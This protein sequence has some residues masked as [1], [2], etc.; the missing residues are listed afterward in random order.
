[1][2]VLLSTLF[3]FLGFL[4]LYAGSL[5]D[6]LPEHS[7]FMLQVENVQKARTEYQSSPLADVLN[8]MDP[9]KMMMSAY[10]KALE[11]G[12]IEEPGDLSV[13]EVEAQVT[14]YSLM[15]KGILDHVEGE[16]ILGV[17]SLEN[18]ITSFQEIETIRSALYED[19]DVENEMESADMEALAKQE[20][21]LETRELFAI[22]NEFYFLAEVKEGDALLAKL[23][24]M[25][26]EALQEQDDEY[27]EV[28]LEKMDWDGLAV[29][30]LKGRDLDPDAEAEDQDEFVNISWWTVK[31]NV[32]I[33]RG[34]EEGL[35][36]T[37]LALDAPPANRLSASPGYVD[38][39]QFLGDQETK[40][41]MDFSR[42]DPLVRLAL[43]PE[44]LNEVAQGVKSPAMVMDWLG[45]DALLPY[46]LGFSTRNDGMHGKARF[47]F[48]RETPL[49]RML[50]DP[51]MDPAPIP[52]FLHKD[53]GQISSMRWS[54]GAGLR[55][56]ETE[57][58]AFQP[59]LTAGLGVVKA[60]MIGQLGMDV[61][62]QFLDHFDT[63]LVMAQQLDA[64]VME[65]MLDMA[66]ESDPAKMMQFRME[67][68]TNGQNYLLGLQLKN[69]E[70]V[71]SGL[72]TLL[73]RVHP[74][75][76]PEP[77]MF[78][79]H[80]IHSPI[81]GGEDS[82]MANLI[83][84]TILDGYLVVAIGNET[85]LHD[86]IR[87]SNEPAS[88]L[89]QDPAFQAFRDQL[90]QG[91]MFEYTPRAVQQSAWS[92]IASSL[93]AAG[94]ELEGLPDMEKLGAV[95]GDSFSTAIRKGTVFETEIHSTFAPETE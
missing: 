50:I 84:Y 56:V 70:L 81:P 22:I 17:G 89:I 37:L 85:M 11:E 60:M 30:T 40:L 52:S 78:Q 63:G 66:E 65:K 75:G 76:I 20:D 67:H 21:D 45:A 4:P 8:D 79:G 43:G 39:M 28:A 68:P 14:K 36:K 2:N 32:W 7:V 12:E 23:E 88:R 69:Q 19:M 95:F 71:T 44:K 92:V 10:A 55:R 90:P 74:N 38:A 93:A 35:K 94:M 46:V 27:S 83:T 41:Y 49:S 33:L 15:M 31:N 29:Y 82:P 24:T 5:A 86:A 57:L 25:L 58:G 48:S 53:M 42:I 1:M 18:A 9:I 87:A 73:A 3:L 72:N 16:L 26:T 61:Q 64:E 91:V 34:T 54:L 77:K 80:A 13:E 47:G 62:S 59:E 6:A 51:S